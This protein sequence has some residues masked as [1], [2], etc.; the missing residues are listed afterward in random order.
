MN[1]SAAWVATTS[2]IAIAR[3]ASRPAL[4]GAAGAAAGT[5]SDASVDRQ[6]LA[7]DEA[8]LQGEPRDHLRGLVGRAGTAQR[9]ERLV[10]LAAARREALRDAAVERAERDDV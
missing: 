7:L 6:H 1:D 5:T 8:V 2:I 3:A 10:V 4:R 9:A